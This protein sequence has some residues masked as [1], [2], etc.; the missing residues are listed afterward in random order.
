[1]NYTVRTE[2][3]IVGSLFIFNLPLL[4]DLTSVNTFF[5]R[6]LYFRVHNIIMDDTRITEKRF[7]VPLGF[8]GNRITVDK[9]RIYVFSIYRCPILQLVITM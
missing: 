9:I 6:G 1:M 3:H 5:I 4:E 2:G 8:W 7:F